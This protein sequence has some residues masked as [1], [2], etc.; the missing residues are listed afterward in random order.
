[1]PFP[2]FFCRAFGV[3]QPICDWLSA[4]DAVF[5]PPINRRVALEPHVGESLRLREGGTEQN[6]D[7]VS[8]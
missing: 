4:R 6:S 1:M 7:E 8:K 3:P 5:G 2:C